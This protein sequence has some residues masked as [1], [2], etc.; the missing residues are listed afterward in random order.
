MKTTT[1]Q[2]DLRKDHSRYEFNR[3]L[4][5]NVSEGR[6][7][8]GTTRSR[9]RGSI[10]NG[11]TKQPASTKLQSTETRVEKRD[12]RQ[13]FSDRSSAPGNEWPGCIRENTATAPARLPPEPTRGEL[14]NHNPTLTVE[15]VDTTDGNIVE[16]GA[17]IGVFNNGRISAAG[18]VSRQHRDETEFARVLVKVLQCLSD[19]IRTERQAERAEDGTLLHPEAKRR[20]EPP[21]EPPASPRGPMRCSYCTWSTK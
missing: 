19:Q 6:P 13:D 16:T 4:T 15:L 1:D 18:Y 14:P 9:A 3:W 7:T 8:P 12:S 2:P 17:V 20:Q 10:R 11:E 5:N 21:H